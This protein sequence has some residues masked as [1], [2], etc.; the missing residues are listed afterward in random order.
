MRREPKQQFTPRTTPLP[1]K[2]LEIIAAGRIV[3]EQLIVFF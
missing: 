2:S 3:A 1:Q